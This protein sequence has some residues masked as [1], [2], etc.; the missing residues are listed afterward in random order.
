MGKHDGVEQVEVEDHDYALFVDA[1]I[2]TSSQRA[3]LGAV[4]FTPNNRIQASLSKPLE[5]AFSVLHAEVLALLMVLQWVH[6]II[7]KLESSLQI[8]DRGQ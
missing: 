5:G 6:N 2:S 1:S 3:G 7:V 4:I 8:L